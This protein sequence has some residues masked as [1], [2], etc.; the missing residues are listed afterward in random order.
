MQ[1][2]ECDLCDPCDHDLDDN[3]WNKK[4]RPRKV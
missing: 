4:S 1:C 2:N 3:Q